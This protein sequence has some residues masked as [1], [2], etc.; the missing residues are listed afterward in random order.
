MPTYKLTYFNARG[1]AEPARLLF[2]LAGVPFEDF[3]MTHGDGTWEKIKDSTPFGQVPVLSVDGTEIPQSMAIIRYLAN[4]FGYAGKTPEE[5][6]WVDAIVDQYKDFMSAFMQFVLAQHN[7]KPTEEVERLKTEVYAPAKETYIK[8]LNGLLEKSK[9]G[10]LVGESLTFADLVV[11]ENLFGL[12][13][14]EHFVAAE[15]PKLLA[16]KE[17]VYGIPAI[18][19]YIKSRPDT[20][21]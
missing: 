9:S 7:G 12:E 8:I 2:H 4:Q 16:L 10:F 13:K 3:R 1:Y 11:A 19:E 6:A 17:N 21:F 15:H 18:K 5:K 14:N 20:Q